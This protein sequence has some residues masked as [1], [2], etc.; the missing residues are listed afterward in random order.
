LQ[1]LLSQIE[2][3]EKTLV[4]LIL[5]SNGPT[6]LE[7]LN[8]AISSIQTPDNVQIKVIHSDV[9]QFTESDIS[10]ASASDALMVG[11]NVKVPGTLK[12]KAEQQKLTLKN[13]DIIYELTEYVEDIAM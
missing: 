13:F 10:L 4:K 6:G 12:K 7:A 3:G 5:K 2:S 8:H 9:G 1:A 11:F